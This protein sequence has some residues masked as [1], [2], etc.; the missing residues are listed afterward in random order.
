MK[1]YLFVP[2]TLLATSL[3]GTVDARALSEDDKSMATPSGGARFSDPDEQLPTAINL[4]AGQQSP[5]AGGIDPSS[6]RYDF[7]PASGSYVPHKN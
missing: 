7:D 5:S 2:L 3:L 1:A 6:V 4:S